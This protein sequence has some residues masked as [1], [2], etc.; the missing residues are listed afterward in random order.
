M[1]NLVSFEGYVDSTMRVLFEQ[2]DRRFA[3]AGE[4]CDLGEWLQMFAFD[5]MGELTFS[6]RLGFLEH[7]GDVDGVM[8]KIWN[9]FKTAAPVGFSFL[10]HTD[11]LAG[12]EE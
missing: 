8:G 2:L 1:S 4:V 5:V 12:F 7:G 6:K 10:Q 3:Q 11:I 9:H